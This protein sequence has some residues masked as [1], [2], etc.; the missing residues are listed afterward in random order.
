M[1]RAP[2]TDDL[3]AYSQPRTS[4]PEG[5]FPEGTPSTPL[6]A[7][8]GRPQGAAVPVIPLPEAVNEERRAGQ[9][10][11]TGAGPRLTCGRGGAVRAGCRRRPW[12]SGH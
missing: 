3:H 10:R 11:V 7:F 12:P 4:L 2:S 1:H 8:P 6:V 5:A 9:G